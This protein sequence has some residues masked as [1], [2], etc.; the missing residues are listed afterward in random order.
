MILSF[1]YNSHFTVYNIGIMA[2]KNN[3]EAISNAALYCPSTD[4]KKNNN[5]NYVAAE[6]I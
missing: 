1:N 2:G 6:L 5:I 3:F 4:N